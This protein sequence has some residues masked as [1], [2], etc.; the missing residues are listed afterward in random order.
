M[1]N[2]GNAL[3]KTRGPNTLWKTRRHISFALR[4]RVK[5]EGDVSLSLSC[6]VILKTTRRPLAD[7]KQKTQRKVPRKI[8]KGSRRSIYTSTN[9]AFKTSFECCEPF[10]FKT[11]LKGKDGSEVTTFNKILTKFT[12]WNGLNYES[13]VNR[14]TASRNRESNR[15]VIIAIN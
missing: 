6:T 2:K 14:N 5:C 1:N 8:C 9:G 10:I 7:S 4:L 3:K 12:S 11:E 13:N 15:R